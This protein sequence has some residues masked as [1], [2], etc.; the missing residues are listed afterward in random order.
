M[1][2]RK[3]IPRFMLLALLA[4]VLLGGALLPAAIDATADGEPYEDI[5]LDEPASFPVDI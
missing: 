2:M 1:R 3:F 5:S 4:S